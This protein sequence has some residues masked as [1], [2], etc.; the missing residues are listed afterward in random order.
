[1]YS[2][3]FSPLMHLSR[4]SYQVRLLRQ[5]DSLVRAIIPTWASDTTCWF[6]LYNSSFFIFFA[7][8]IL[9]IVSIVS[10][11]LNV[12]NNQAA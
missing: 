6:L 12:A 11:S 1:M 2:E 7:P 10:V 4:I 5:S 8:G 9:W 3:Y